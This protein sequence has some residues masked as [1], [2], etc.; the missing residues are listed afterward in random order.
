VQTPQKVTTRPR[1]LSSAE[2]AEARR[3]YGPNKLPEARQVSAWSILAQQFLSPLIYIILVAAVVSLIAGERTDFAIIMVVVAVDVLMG[4]VQEYRAQQAYLALRSYLRPVAVVIRDGRRQEVDVTDIV[5]GDLVALDPGDRV[6]ADGVIVE[7]ADLAIDEAVL[8]G[9]SE[10][11]D[12]SPEP[13]KDRAFMGTTVARGRG[14]LLV[15]ET[16]ARTQFGR[17]AASVQEEQE[18]P[19]RVRL[20][21]FSRTLTVLVAGVSALIFITGT[22]AGRSFLEMLRVSI[23][24]AIAAVPEGLLIAVTVVLVLGMRAILRRNGL[25]RRLLAVE[26]LGSVMVICT[27]KTGTLTEGRLRVTRTAYTDRQRAIEVMVLCNDLESPLETALWEQARNELGVDPQVLADRAQRLDEVPFSSE[28]KHMIT[29][30]RL[31]GEELNY[32]K[33]APEIVLEMCD[34]SASEREGIL[35][36]VDVWAD[37]GLKPLGLAYRPLGPIRERRGYRWAGL[38]GMEDPIREG[39]P[40][41]I[42]QC[43]EAGIEVKV[44]TGDYRRTAERVSRSIGLAVSDEQVIE[45]DELERMSDEELE[46][47]VPETVIFSRIRPSDK[48]RIVRALQARG[49]VTAMIGDGVNDA[50]A[51]RRANIGV[52]VGTASD[53]AKETADLVLLDSNFR[54]IV[55]AVEEGRTIFENIR[56][57][58]SY[59]LSNSFSEVIAIFVAQLLGWPPVL[60]VAQILWIHLICDG[61]PDIVLGFEPTEPG[62]MRE[63]PRPLSAPILP[64]VGLALIGVISGSSA[65]FAL[66]LFGRYLVSGAGVTLAQTVV[67]AVFAVDSMI[68]IFGYRSLRRPLLRTPPIGQNLPLVAAI[69]AGLAL[70]IAAVSVPFLRNVLGL[71]PLGPAEWALAFGVSLALLAIVEIAKFVDARLQRRAGGSAS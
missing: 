34:I 31:D 1:G 43:R 49:E 3:R 29:A 2:V 11:V 37:A 8:T 33:G 38:V 40:E 59:T 55:A 17:I 30:V 22:L 25:V 67:F 4:F 26:T 10:P 71:A 52:V 32:L 63:P 62:I 27:D 44:I 70:G 47:R 42:Q 56:K 53:V 16:G 60:T 9:E 66:V 20:R 7:S 18:S 61:P 68:Y 41:A 28:A 19:L 12:K 24:L 36:Q 45:G 39:V 21:G 50:P 54:T 35:K 57:V 13:G 48:L 46:R 5:P 65:L 51:L 58:V 64:R 6:P 15:T 14:L 69:S 23:V